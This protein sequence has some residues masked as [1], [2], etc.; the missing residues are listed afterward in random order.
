MRRGRKNLVTWLFVA[1][2]TFQQHEINM[3]C[4]LIRVNYIKIYIYNPKKYNSLASLRRH[5]RHELVFV[6][7]E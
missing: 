2:I 3:I 7:V 6:L 5:S 4:L 1:R